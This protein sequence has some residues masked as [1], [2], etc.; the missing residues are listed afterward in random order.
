MTL[1]AI[2]IRADGVLT[3]LDELRR[4][5]LNRMI[6]D[7]GFAWQCDR[8]TYATSLKFGAPQQRM[9]SF[10]MPRLGYQRASGDAEQLASAMVRRM[11]S[12]LSEMLQ[13]AA[14]TTRPGMRDLIVAAKA[15]GLRLVLATPL[16]PADA[17][18][19]ANATLGQDGRSRFDVIITAPPT[20]TDLPLDKVYAQVLEKLGIPADHCLVLECKSQGLEAAASVGLRTLVFRSAFA[21]DTPLD[22]AV[23]VADDVP[24]LIGLT[25]NSRLD[26]FTGQQRSELIAALQ[27]LHAGHSGPEGSSDRSSLLKVSN[28]LQSKGSAV[29]SI[30]AA[31]SMREL[32]QQLSTEAIGA[33]V[34]VSESGQLAG[35]ISER[36]VARGVAQYGA[37]LPGLPV[38][39][40]M[41]T[42]VI[43]CAPGDSI[44]NI[45]KIMTQRRIR[46]LP[47]VERGDLV[48][49]VSIGDVL[50]YRLDEVQ[51]EANVLRD[52]ALAKR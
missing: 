22:K 20:A 35:I 46:H 6:S 33:M 3:D 47:V 15:E 23:F 44:A 24:A 7:A 30:T 48:G 49:L 28:I 36:D 52:Y 8:A 13:T 17:E 14:L 38:S 18:C 1:E 29:K 34:V 32:S 19:I 27:R 45:S 2:I 37:A 25:R 9:I 50:K 51:Y 4:A 11:A 10:F 12:I 39:S 26:P 40:L 41:T 5:A 21:S 16:P 43:T 42:A 31:A